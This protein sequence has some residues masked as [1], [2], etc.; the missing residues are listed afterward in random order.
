MCIHVMLTVLI[1]Q[2]L[3]HPQLKTNGI[4][5]VNL[6]GIIS[7]FLCLIGLKFF[8]KDSLLDDSR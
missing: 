6:F 2:D 7:N 8:E 1:G 5:F 3:S 4:S